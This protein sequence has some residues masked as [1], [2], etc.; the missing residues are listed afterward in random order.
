MTDVELIA[1]ALKGRCYPPESLLRELGHQTKPDF[2]RL[3]RV[4]TTIS[5]GGAERRGRGWDREAEG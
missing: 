1:N 2:L 3:G 4:G 5:P